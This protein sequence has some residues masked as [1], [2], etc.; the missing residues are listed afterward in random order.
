MPFFGRK[1]RIT[2]NDDD[3][4]NNV[5]Q[6]EIPGKSDFYQFIDAPLYM[7]LFVGISISEMA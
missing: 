5:R 3:A 4:I 1:N 2:R 6:G 7:T